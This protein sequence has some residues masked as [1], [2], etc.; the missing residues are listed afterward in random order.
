MKVFQYNKNKE[1]VREFDKVICWD[2]NFVEYD[3]GGRCRIYCGED[4]YFTDKEML[5]AEA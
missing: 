3:N 5:E 1:L 4:E 2:F